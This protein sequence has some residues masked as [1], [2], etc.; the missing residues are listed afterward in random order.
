MLHKLIKESSQLCKGQ[1]P[2]KGYSE[3]PH[4]P[5]EKQIPSRVVTWSNKIFVKSL[6]QIQAP[7]LKKDRLYG[8][9]KPK[10]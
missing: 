6:E 2:V 8:L 9:N 7:S 3:S 5:T 1:T 10:G 4:S